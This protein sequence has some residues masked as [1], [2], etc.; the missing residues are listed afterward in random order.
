MARKSG[1]QQ[2][3]EN[4]NSVYGAFQDVAKDWEYEDINKAKLEEIGFSPDDMGDPEATKWSYLGEE[5]DTKP[6]TDQMRGLKYKAMGDV[7]AKYGDISGAMDM[8]LRREEIDAKAAENKLNRELFDELKFQRGVGKSDQLRAGNANTTADTG[9]KNSQSA[10]NAEDLKLAKQLRDWKVAGEMYKSMNL[11]EDLISK[12]NANSITERTMG[13]NIA[14]TNQENQA[15]GAKGAL[16]GYQDNRTLSNL[17]VK[18]DILRQSMDSEILGNSD[19]EFRQN[20]IKEQFATKLPPE[21]ADA[22]I[23]A[24]DKFSINELDR[25]SMMLVKKAQAAARKGPAELAKVYDAM[26][27]PTKVRYVNENGVHKFVEYG[28]DGDIGELFASDSL[29]G[30]NAKI[31]E[32]LKSPFTAYQY[33]TIEL[34]QQQ[35]KANI[36]K[37]TSETSLIDKQAFTEI[38]TQD[39]TEAKTKLLAA[40]EAKVREEI[41]ASKSG[42]AGREKIALEGL[43]DLLGDP[44]FALLKESRPE[45]AA[46]LQADYMTTFGLSKSSQ[47]PSGIPQNVWDAMTEV[48]KK[49]FQQQQ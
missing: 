37:T 40:Q 15:R 9:L 35:K 26:N 23:A 29:E 1:W 14:A 45:L 28:E 16:A 43:A 49:A 27:G 44:N 20:W 46:Q 47:A 2:F 21:E 19:P 6:T 5:F 39:A 32:H 18:D 3:A 13:S 22:A 41:R 25:T 34:D 17:Q 12:R 30:M 11:G 48:E 42:L 10:L 7:M 24:I 38:L 8:Q 36:D 31:G 4:F 33:A